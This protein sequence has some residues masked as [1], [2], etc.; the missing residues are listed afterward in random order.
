MRDWIKRLF[1]AL[2]FLTIIPIP[3]YRRDDAHFYQQAALCFSMVGILIGIVLWAGCSL[4]IPF[5]PPLVLAALMTVSLSAISGFLHLDGVADCG[6]GFLCHKSSEY[7]LEIMRDSRSG[8]MGVIVLYA[9]LLLKFSAI[10]SIAAP[11]L[12]I[13]IFLLPIAGR[14]AIMLTM[15][16]LPYARS[17]QGLGSLFY[18]EKR[19]Q[20]IIIALLT[21]LLP[22]FLLPP[23]IGILF[24]MSTVF[25]PFLFGR[26]CKRLIGGVTGDTLG[27]ACEITETGVALVLAFVLT[28]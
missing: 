11:H 22:L 16:T 19:H 9:L 26:I 8:A 21:L 5:T 14:C 13:S 12:A 23:Q 24:C 1:T 6:D 17:E 10:A 27:A 15:A 7:K 4:L 3:W 28:S 20:L 25:I 2:R 18:P